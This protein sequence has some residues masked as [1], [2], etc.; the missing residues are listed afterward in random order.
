MSKLV[1]FD[2]PTMEPNDH[3]R[4]LSLPPEIRNAIY[5]A[6]IHTQRDPPDSP[7]E[8]GPR[9]KEEDTSG[10]NRA[11]YYPIGP[12]SWPTHVSLILCNRQVRS[13]VLDI[14]N[15]QSRG[16][17]CRLDCILK[18]LALWP[19]WTSYPG[20]PQKIDHLEMNFR[21]FDVR[22]GRDPFWGNGGPGMML[23]PLF[24][25]LNHFIHHGPQFIYT[26]PLRH[27]P[28]LDTLII[29]ISYQ[30]RIKYDH[31]L[32]NRVRIKN[33]KSRIPIA[34]ADMIDTVAR[35]GVLVGQIERIG[36]RCGDYESIF[37]TGKFEPSENVGE[38]WEQYGFHWGCDPSL[39]PGP[40]V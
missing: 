38:R 17:T 11:V 8:A 35:R 24:W 1:S 4:L 20:L 12:S 36:V 5:V 14:L 22:S 40:T 34:I 39:A 16:L 23:A 27:K 33:Y 26:G 13:E 10:W 7:D 29:N 30:D 6:A 32:S 37:E 9:L 2:A 19:T 15:R 3:F 21:L 28:R 18:G 31:G 25:M